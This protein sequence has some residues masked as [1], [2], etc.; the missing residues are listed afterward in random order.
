MLFVEGKWFYN[1]VLAMKKNGLK[2]KDINS[3]NIK[4]VKHFDKDRNEIIS[5]L[6]QIS[7][8][9]KQA[10]VARM[11]ANEKTIA[12]LVKNRHQN[13]GGQLKFKSE[14]TCI[15]LKQYG[16]TYVFKSANKVK[17][18]GI[19]GVVLVKTGNQLQDVDELANANLIKRPDGYYLKVI[20][21]INKENFKEKQKNVKEIG[22]DFGIKTNL[23]T[24]EGEKIDVSVGESDRLKKLQ[25][26]LFRRVKG[27][28]N[29]H[30]TIKQ[31]KREYQK[32]SNRKKDKANKIVSKL[33]A[34]NCII[35][36]DEQI[37]NWHKGL[38]GKQVQ[39]SC[40][41]LIKAKLKALPQ[42]VI[43]DKWI[44]TTKWCPVC[45]KKHDISLDERTY[46]C[47]CGYSFDRDIHSAKNMLAIKDFV[48]ENL[49]FVPTGHRK[50]R[51][52]SSRPLLNAA[53][54]PASLDAEV[55][56]CY[57]FSVTQS[58]HQIELS[59]A[60]ICH[61]VFP[62]LQSMSGSDETSETIA[63]GSIPASSNAAF[64][65]LMSVLLLVA[66]CSAFSLI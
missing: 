63:L 66:A 2:L 28:N 23:T 33:K 56:R 61:N 58:S 1:Y 9:Q 57:V 26:E 13:Y 48:F 64:H 16:N 11:I 14:L 59:I 37:V 27:S 8:Q 10:L 4:E 50:S 35:M 42:T 47:N 60:I 49:G 38:F 17:I 55:R 43:L 46:V 24:S 29:R 31:I 3:T 40:L 52:W 25:R 36:Q 22:L 6:S 5:K 51:S 41:G 65:L 18:A 21:F 32:L 45:H 34:Y 53:M 62:K 15:P 30:R 54:R 39:H 19:S 12:S 44:P 7:S 20:A